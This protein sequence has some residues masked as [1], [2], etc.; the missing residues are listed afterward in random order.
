MWVLTAWCHLFASSHPPPSLLRSGHVCRA[1]APISGGT[2]GV[3][4]WHQLSSTV[5][6]R[7]EEQLPSS[8]T[9]ADTSFLQARLHL[10][11]NAT[12]IIH[13]HSALF[14]LT[15]SQERHISWFN[16]V[17]SANALKERDR[18]TWSHSGETKHETFLGCDGDVWG[19]GGGAQQRS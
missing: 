13:L 12:I 8:G 5:N 17:T 16:L 2:L 9:P 18:R 11:H 1:P 19:D 7:R 3:L 6:A 14:A 4:Y 10:H 15:F